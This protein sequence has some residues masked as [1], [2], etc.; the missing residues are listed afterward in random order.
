MNLR[1]NFHVENVTTFEDYLKSSEGDADV[2]EV[3][4][5]DTED[6]APKD[7]DA[8][9]TVSQTREAKLSSGEKRGTMDIDELYPVFWSL[10][11]VFSNPQKLF[12][13]EDFKQFRERLETTLAKFKE[14]PKVIQSTDSDRLRATQPWADDEKDEFA[15][16]FNPKFLTSRDLFKL[17]V[18]SATQTRRV[19]RY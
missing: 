6:D 3:E 15:S 14:V 7:E 5:K 11:H 12:E 19:G 18:R 9:E 1:G 2:M 17:Q 13:E 4:A 16:T 8:A 10:Q